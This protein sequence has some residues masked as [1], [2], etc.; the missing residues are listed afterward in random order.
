MNGIGSIIGQILFIISIIIVL[1][2]I[3]K[4]LKPFRYHRNRKW[5]TMMLKFSF[6]VYIAVFMVFVFWYIFVS[7]T[8][9]FSAFNENTVTH[10]MRGLSQSQSSKVFQ[11]ENSWVYMLLIMIDIFLVLPVLAILIRRKIKK[12]IWFNTLFSIVNLLMSTYLI[13]YLVSK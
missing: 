12:R 6:L 10:L 2:I 1:V 8:L 11:Q 7:K 5:S 4:L 3:Y 13:Y 9:T